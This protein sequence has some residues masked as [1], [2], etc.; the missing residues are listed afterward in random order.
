MVEV[1][2]NPKRP[3]VP[4]VVIRV[5]RM[6]NP[7]F[8]VCMSCGAPHRKR[9]ERMYRYKG[10]EY[11]ALRGKTIKQVRLIEDN[12]FNALILE[13]EDN[14]RA[15]FTLE[16]RISFAVAPEI[17]GTAPN[18]DLINCRPLGTRSIPPHRASGLCR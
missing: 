3:E 13:F 18:G 5:S 12:E 7:C 1:R 17:M 11:P 9:N 4:D 16:T 8:S 14:T 6:K 10:I 15:R 2:E